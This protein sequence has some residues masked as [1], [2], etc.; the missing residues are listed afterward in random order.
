MR[1][2]LYVTNLP[3]PPGFGLRTGQIQ[4][5]APD[6]ARYCLKNRIFLYVTQYQDYNLDN[7]LNFEVNVET[8]LERNIHSMY[9]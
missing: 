6:H 2:F 7:P 9:C 1:N 4:R 5:N 8:G 3:G